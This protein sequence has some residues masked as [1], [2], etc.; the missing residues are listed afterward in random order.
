MCF[1]I[2]AISK[3]FTRTNKILVSFL[4]AILHFTPAASLLAQEIK[5]ANPSSQTITQAVQL[6]E[7]TKE[8]AK[9]VHPVR[10]TGVVTCFDRRAELCFVQD[11]TA[12]VY[13]YPKSI[14]PELKTGDRV[15][16]VG[17]AEAGLFSP[18]LD[19]GVVR[20]LGSTNLPTPKF[21]QVQD[22]A[23]GKEDCQWVQV[24]GVIQRATEEWGHLVLDLVS[25]SSRLKVR[26]LKY[27]PGSTNRFL[28]ARVRL[29]GVAGISPDK[30]KPLINFHLFVPSVEQIIVA[31]A[32]V[33][34]PF[35]L[36]IRTARNFMTF[37]R[38]DML[39]HRIH[40]R[41]TVLFQSPGVRVFIR[42][43][44]GGIQIERWDGAAIEPGD[45]VDV[46]GFPVFGNPDAKLTDATLRV[47]GKASIAAPT[48]ITVA[49]GLTGDFD[50]E[51]VQMEGYFT[52]INDTS[53]EY[54][55]LFLHADK[56]VFQ[57][58]LPKS[59]KW[60]GI[61]IP[62][63]GSRLQ[64]TGVCAMPVYEN[65]KS[66]SFLLWMRSSADLKILER[67][68]NLTTG[69]PPFL[70]ILLG[71]VFA[72][73]LAWTL[74]ARKRTTA[75]LLRSEA[76]L[77]KALSERERIARDL[78]DSLIQSIYALGLNL[79]S[80]KS[81]VAENPAEVENRL[82]K[83]LGDLNGVI[84]EVRN[85]ILGLE[86][87]ELKGQ[88][89]KTALKSVVLTLG[90]SRSPQFSL[91]IDSTAAGFLSS[92]QATQLLRIAREAV[93]NSVR[94]AG[95]E[96]TVLSL[97]S[98]DGKIRF[99]VQDNGTGFNTSAPPPEGHGLR[100]MAARA[101]EMGADFS[102][103]SKIGQ[104]TRI[105]LDIPIKNPHESP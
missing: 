86:S 102:I 69:V 47:A 1:G 43:E 84:R 56:T 2:S 70:W 42:D 31:K 103:V 78:H 32:P 64:I 59:Q 3:S 27:P 100:N 26:V 8:E 10:L 5:S 48:R 105:L 20:I 49:Q 99:E 34:D 35:T 9:R 92:Q 52:E 37:S 89:F 93:S 104:G 30:R 91:Q 62:P 53:P 88:E 76:E 58:R 50:N 40:F 82:T 15:E 44:A 83:I 77:R 73:G 90:E 68:P 101:R 23:S 85:F 33:A 81:L 18:F 54:R 45:V 61:L 51:L 14:V 71:L 22:L 29:Q 28:D 95:A 7:L 66:S 13:V 36:P 55:I 24:E 98:H 79:E 63:K 72:V 67:P 80:C 87:D 16:V 97:Q 11:S 38:D 94:H 41:G 57:A 17:V 25:G 75:A 65:E 39:E 60:T 21:V 96:R 46:V 4:C 19:R 74:L 6:I 12:G